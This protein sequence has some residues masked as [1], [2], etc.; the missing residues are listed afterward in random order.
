MQLYFALKLHY[1][2]NITITVLLFYTSHFYCTVVN[3]SCFTKPFWFQNFKDCTSTVTVWKSCSVSL[4]FQFLSECIEQDF[5]VCR[6]LS[7]LEYEE[8]CEE[9]LISITEKFEDLTDSAAIGEDFDVS[10]SVGFVI[11]CTVSKVFCM[12]D[13]CCIFIL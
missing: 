1:L 8:I 12:F 4:R 7:D 9:T 11:I 3:S 6:E 13:I 2:Y 5:V 10:F